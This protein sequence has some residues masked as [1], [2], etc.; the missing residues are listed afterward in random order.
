M[1]VIMTLQLING[2]AVLFGLPTIVG[3]LIWLGK[4]IHL[5]EIIHQ[6]VGILK[7]NVKAMSDHLAKADDTFR[8][9]ELR[10]HSPLR[11]RMMDCC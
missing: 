3:A 4:K 9:N 5:I 1:N 10:G 7:F 8:P 11:S 6:D 2:A